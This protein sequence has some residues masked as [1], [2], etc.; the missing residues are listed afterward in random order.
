MSFVFSGSCYLL[1]YCFLLDETAPAQWAKF[2]RPDRIC[3]E[4][5]GR[6]NQKV[7]P[8]SV[9]HVGGSVEEIQKFIHIQRVTWV[10]RWR[11]S[12]SSSIFSESHGW[13]GR[14]NPQ[15]HPY[16]ASHMGRSVEVIQKFIHPYSVSHMG[17]SDVIG[18]TI[19]P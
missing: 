12:T 18:C 17:R 13:I 16:S 5:H 14:G 6:G 1:W 4:L 7:H 15:V 9:N 8:Y 2:P 10:D 3:P 11:K 19:G